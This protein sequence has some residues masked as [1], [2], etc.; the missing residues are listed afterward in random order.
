[1]TKRAIHIVA[2]FAVTG[3]FFV[4]ALSFVPRPAHAQMYSYPMMNYSGYNNYNSGYNNYGYANTN[5]YRPIYYPVYYPVYYYAT[6]MY[7]YYPSY[8]GNYYGYGS[9]GYG[10]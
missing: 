7:Y 4:T 2:V 8:T 5:Y 10:Y 3:A 1:M 9:G 6:P